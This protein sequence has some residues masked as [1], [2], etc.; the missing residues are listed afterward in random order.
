MGMALHDF[1]LFSFR[2]AAAL[3]ILGP[4]LA[5]SLD[6]ILA[7]RQANPNDRINL[8]GM[9]DCGRFWCEESQAVHTND[10]CI[11]VGQS[12]EQDD[13]CWQQYTRDC[14]CDLQTGLYCAW[15]CNWAEWFEVEDWFS[16]HCPGSPAVTLDFSGL[17][18]CARGCFDDETFDTGCI[19]QSSN[20]FCAWGDL[21][22]CHENCGSDEELS[23]IESWLRGACNLDVESATNAL[24]D[25]FFMISDDV[26]EPT[27]APSPSTTSSQGFSWDEIF[28]FVVLGITGTVIIGLWIYSWMGARQRRTP[29]NLSGDNG[30]SG[31]SQK[32]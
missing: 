9:P 4:R 18:D 25:G 6:A 23:Q 28:I 3:F 17:P 27:R 22:G 2:I 1:H 12:C 30:T 21:F 16:D 31:I 32:E 7:Q 24:R 26:V 13:S 10:T 19:T 15:P 11:P 5:S 8:D 20:C 14:Y 29:L